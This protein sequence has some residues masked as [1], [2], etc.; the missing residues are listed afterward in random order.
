MSA[1]LVTSPPVVMAPREDGFEVVWGVSRLS[2]GWLEWKDAG[3]AEPGGPDADPAADQAAM[4]IE[5][6]ASASELVLTMRSLAG[7]VVHDIRL[8]PA[9]SGESHAGRPGTEV[10]K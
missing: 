6:A 9:A 3:G 8:A 2:R 1:P 7:D 10:M 4:W 5:G